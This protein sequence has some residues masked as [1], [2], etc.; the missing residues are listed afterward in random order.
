MYKLE[1]NPTRGAVRISSKT[2]HIT[3][4][5][6]DGTPDGITEMLKD[7]CH[8]LFDGLINLRPKADH[9]ACALYAAN[10]REFLSCSLEGGRKNPI[11]TH[12]WHICT[13]RASSW[14][15]DN[16][17]KPFHPNDAE[18]LEKPPKEKKTI[19]DSRFGID[20]EG[21]VIPVTEEAYDYSKLNDTFIEYITPIQSIRQPN[22][23][24]LNATQ[25]TLN[26]DEDASSMRINA[27]LATLETCR[28]LAT[29]SERAHRNELAVFDQ[30][31][32]ETI[33]NMSLC[34]RI[35]APEDVLQ[36][37]KV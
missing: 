21:C 18:D 16:P 5:A 23:D 37:E 29:F 24:P 22:G 12:C 26:L 2:Y 35:P 11:Q 1:R 25:E 30:T 7:I 17:P 34:G 31:F 33:Q 20:E 14:N 32:S 36:A 8:V 3:Q 15:D 10:Y 19:E 4:C 28:Y 13:P 9:S 27:H 6:G